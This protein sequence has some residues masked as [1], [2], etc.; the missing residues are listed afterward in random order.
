MKYSLLDE[1]L[2]KLKL[3]KNNLHEFSALGTKLE[4][5]DKIKDKYLKLFRIRKKNLDIS[6]DI[7]MYK[8]IC[9]IYSLMFNVTTK[10][11]IKKKID[12]EYVQIYL[13][14]VDNTN[15]EY[16]KKLFDFRNESVKTETKLKKNIMKPKNPIINGKKERPFRV[17]RT[18]K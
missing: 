16:H 2:D 8:E 17:I 11:R 18:S 5:V 10:K 3:N 7:G 12:D 1:M 4:D 13:Y 9:N 15:I 14:T 6:T